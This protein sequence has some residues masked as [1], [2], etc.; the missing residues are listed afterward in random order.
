MKPL[1]LEIQ[2]F[3]PFAERQVIDFSLLGETPLFLI[4]GQ[5]GTG[6]SS[7]LDAICFA[8][9][10]VTTGGEREAR[11]MRCDHADPD[12]LTEVVFDFAIGAEAY[13]I[14]RI[15]EQE[16]PK[17]SGDGTTT[18]KP[19]GKMW[20]LEGA[21]E[22]ALLVPKNV[23]EIDKQVQGILGLKAEQFRQ[24]MVL[25]QGKFRDLLMEDSAG[26]EVIMKQLFQTQIYTEIEKELSERG[27]DIRKE[28]EGLNNQ[29]KGILQSL[30]ASTLDDAR[31]MLKIHEGDR[32]IAGKQRDQAAKAHKDASDKLVQGSRA[33]AKF[34]EVDRLQKQLSEH[35][36]KHEQIKQLE[37]AIMLARQALR[38]KPLL[39][40]YEREVQSE[41]DLQGQLDSSAKELGAAEAEK[42]AVDRTFSEAQAE[43]VK[44]EGWNRELTVLE[45][46][47]SQA[48]ELTKERQLLES[49][50]SEYK[51]AEAALN[52]SNTSF[53][54]I[55]NRLKDGEV[56]S[57][58]LSEAIKV[59]PAKRE[60]C[61]QFIERGKKRRQ[62]E[63]L[64]AEMS[65]ESNV[66][67]T[68]KKELE[69]AEKA[70][71]ED[72]ITAKDV[73]RQWHLGQAA[74][75]AQE[76]EPGQPCPVC[77]SEDHPQPAEPEDG[78][79]V[80]NEQKNAA[81]AQADKSRGLVESARSAW[82]EQDKK[83]A[84]LNGQVN[85]QRDV[86]SVDADQT[87]ESFEER[88]R[89]IKADVDDLELKEKQLEE[90][91]TSITSM[92][93][94]REELSKTIEAQDKEEQTH[95]D[96]VVSLQAQVDA[97]EK[98]LP[99]KYR[100]PESIT[101]AQQ[102]L[103]KQVEVVKA[104][105]KSAQQAQK[106]ADETVAKAK[107]KQASLG[108]QLGKAQSKAEQAQ[109][110]WQSA[111]DS[112]AFDSQ[113]AYTEALTEESEIQRMDGECNQ[114]H[115]DTQS[116]KGALK[117]AEQELA[118][119]QRLD[120]SS[121]ES[122]EAVSK[123]ALNE[124]QKK[125][126]NVNAK[127]QKFKTDIGQVEKINQDNADLNESYQVVGTLG[128]LATGQWGNRIN[129][130]R[131]VLG[132]LLDQVLESAS[133][134]LL[135]MSDG[136][137]QLLRKFDKAKG[138]RASGL[139][140]EVL[141]SYT[142]LSRAVATLSGGESFMAALSLALGLSDIVQGYAGGIK[143]DAL[144]IDEGFGSLD[145]DSLDLAIKTL[146]DLQSSGRMIGVISHVSEMKEQ[147]PI[148]I[149][150]NKS[151]S[152]STLSITA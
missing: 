88:Y 60:E 70:Y 103:S 124:S 36:V 106:D 47:L 77:G 1:R 111:L 38:I 140:M 52:Q 109:S 130:Q 42:T 96:Q 131:F 32:E 91:T 27:K 105:F 66:A 4:N 11:Q 152:G 144:F 78:A 136:R 15:P 94:D 64:K 65:K 117:Q 97:K 81:A 114:Y 134:R 85:E 121:L 9:Y 33:N 137:Y 61:K 87:I 142:G 127:Y 44:V 79:L 18:Q 107:A 26:R 13:R 84:V 62:L 14:E 6:K 68:L 118:G 40:T 149:D 102:T 54:D 150:V 122:A 141:D 67:D 73:T 104:R 7:I 50:S 148:R 143:L 56:Q 12:V 69:T 23:S 71:Q 129:L 145:Q 128:E 99:E 125:W 21:E 95:R 82:Q 123:D 48:Q 37:G 120:L 113:D 63:A 119:K 146:V 58:E 133:T 80:T 126:D 139:D 5:T 98:E 76:L 30:E 132:V 41:K 108:D 8:L 53:K 75:L 112:S 89:G 25:P 83:V 29:I 31:E 19:A 90:L 20:R 116:L 49:A 138:N 86:L 147:M 24:V 39:D 55:E 72:E 101:T 22:G 51:A 28:M 92:R 16:R 35:Q 45:R 34:E 135:S 151:T 110:Q 10:G 3:G 2:A 43:Q 100:D 17:K 57:T 59:L 46:H 74:L 93:K 115:Q